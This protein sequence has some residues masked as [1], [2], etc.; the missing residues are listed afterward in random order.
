MYT[1]I[2]T[3]MHTCLVYAH[4]HALPGPWPMQGTCMCAY[5]FREAQVG[6]A[7]MGHNNFKIELTNHLSIWVLAFTFLRHWSIAD[8]IDPDADDGV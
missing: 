1:Y 8:G 2:H 6:S 5:V 4:A 3:L 7:H